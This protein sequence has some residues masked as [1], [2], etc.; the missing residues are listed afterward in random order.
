VPVHR[1]ALGDLQTPAL[2]V[3]S[4]ILEANLAAMA[5]ALPGPRLRPHVKAHKCT[6]LA[7]LQHRAGHPGFTCATLREVEGLAAAGLGA[8]LL[9]A[10]EVVDARRLSPLLAGGARVTVA[11]DSPETVAAAR[12]A[13]VREVLIDV[14]VGLPRCGCPPEEAGALADLARRQG[15]E[16]RGVMGYEGH[17]VGVEDRAERT[18]L[19][20]QSMALLWAA[21]GDVGGPVVSAG[22]TGS[23]DL[24]TA[25]TEIQAGSYVLMDTAY[26]RLGLPFE[27][28]LT[29]L[30]T[31]VS[32]NRAGW[33]VADC[34]LKALG[35]DHGNPTVVGGGPVW[36]C[37]DEH[38]TFGPAEGER[39]PAVGDRIR[40]LPAHVDPTV[41]YH[42]HLHLVDS[43]REG[44]VER[45]PVDLR[46]W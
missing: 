41:A 38:V 34:G 9:L 7:R 13:G 33:A 22:A 30:A 24:N 35:M 23:Y 4:A 36:F 14:N 42:Q 10:N 5:A 12:A 25:A 43:R 2:L 27:P 19:V 17:A 46:G 28:A 8:D 45:W 18:G 37:S 20:E 16:V 6:E 39:L 32:V 40:V 26:A 1:A 31:V 3:E 44:V 21:H 15:L 11:V 29:V